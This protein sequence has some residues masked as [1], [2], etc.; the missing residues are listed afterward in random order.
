MTRQSVKISYYRAIKRS[1]RWD[2]LPF[3]RIAIFTACIACISALGVLRHRILLAYLQHKCAVF[4]RDRDTVVYDGYPASSK[5]LLA[6]LPAKY[7]LDDGALI[8]TETWDRFARAMNVPS[9]DRASWFGLRTSE[10]RSVPFHDAAI[11]LH[12]M[13]SPSGRD[14]VVAVGMNEY[15]NITAVVVQPGSVLRRPTLMRVSHATI[16]PRTRAILDEGARMINGPRF[17]A[18][19]SDPLDPSS[20]VFGLEVF[21][22]KTRLR[23]HLTDEA[24][25]NIQAEEAATL[26]EKVSS[27]LNAGG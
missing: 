10:D 6:K 19:T 5:G 22:I 4:E 13:R 21:G 2:R 15:P 8:Q 18:G 9:T 23:G 7:V 20:F 24:E 12:K 11:F 17:F 3:S 14:Y 25:V 27:R 1:W 16:D 26:E